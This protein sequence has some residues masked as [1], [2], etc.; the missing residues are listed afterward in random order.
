MKEKVLQKI[1]TVLSENL[2]DTLL[3]DIEECP[4]DF[5]YTIAVI[6]FM[7]ELMKKNII[8]DYFQLFDEFIIYMVNR[9][10]TNYWAR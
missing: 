9:E 7:T 4:K 2:S 6:N 5:P 1:I 10:I 3:I 8:I